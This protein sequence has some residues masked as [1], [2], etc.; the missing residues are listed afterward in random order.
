MRRPVHHLRQAY[1]APCK[2]HTVHRYYFCATTDACYSIH[3]MT[4]Y[5]VFMSMLTIPI[6]KCGLSQNIH[7][8]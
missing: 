3:I 8:M 4:L 6:S 5:G 2:E 7:G 1:A